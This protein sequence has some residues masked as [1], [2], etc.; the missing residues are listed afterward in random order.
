MTSV[1]QEIN[2]MWEY[3][4]KEKNKNP[5][6]EPV[7]PNLLEPKHNTLLEAMNEFQPKRTFNKID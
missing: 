7:W 3:L 1:E 6:L 2:S 5:D 4:V